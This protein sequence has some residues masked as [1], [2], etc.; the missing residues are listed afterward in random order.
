[1]LRRYAE[2]VEEIG[3]LEELV[4]NQRR[5]LELQHSTR[6]GGIYDD[7]ITQTMVD[8]EEE[9]VRQLEEKIK[10]MQDKVFPPQCS[11]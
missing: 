10:T 5:E 4:E 7:D 6:F 8:E 3:R 2:V 11:G 1:M 9:K